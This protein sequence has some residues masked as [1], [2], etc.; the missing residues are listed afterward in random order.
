MLQWAMHALLLVSNRVHF[1]HRSNTAM[2]NS[3]Q[4][5]KFL[6]AKLLQVEPLPPE[7]V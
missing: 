7:D 6:Q 4:L 2:H 3:Q 5:L 1:A